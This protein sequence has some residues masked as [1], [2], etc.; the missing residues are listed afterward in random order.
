MPIFC[1]ESEDFR[2]REFRNNLKLQDHKELYGTCEI[3]ICPISFPNE[4]YETASTPVYRN[5]DIVGLFGSDTPIPRKEDLK[6]GRRMVLICDSYHRDEYG[7]YRPIL[8]V[9]DLIQ[10]CG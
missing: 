3:F 1:F 7:D 6:P 5:P 2:L 8:N 10:E 4:L 9:K